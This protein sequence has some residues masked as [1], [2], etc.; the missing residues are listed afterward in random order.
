MLKY[1][2]FSVLVDLTNPIAGT[3]LDY[4]EFSSI[5]TTVKCTWFGFHDPESGVPTVKT[6]VYRNGLEIQTFAFGDVGNY[7]E[8]EEHTFNLQH[9]EYVTIRVEAING[10]TRRNHSMTD[11]FLVDRTPPN[12]DY[13]KDTENGFKYQSFSDRLDLR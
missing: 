2:S 1:I 4:L 10:A 5:V 6:T 11:G 3:V 8:Y 13:L 9:K 12:L 7:S